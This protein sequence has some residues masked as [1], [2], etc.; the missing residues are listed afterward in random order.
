[1]V[2]SFVV[3]NEV[4]H[5]STAVRPDALLVDFIA[6][7]PPPNPAIPSPSPHS[8]PRLPPC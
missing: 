2:L 3:T 6:H 7:Q 4:G 1:M 8:S 5:P